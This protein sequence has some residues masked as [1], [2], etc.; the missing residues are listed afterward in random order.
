MPKTLSIAETLSITE[1]AAYIGWP[2][3]I[4]RRWRALGTGP[5]FVKAGRLVR[6]RRAAL[7]RWLDEQERGVASGA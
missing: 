2:V 7:D 1:A 6:Y 4:M 5:K 3:E